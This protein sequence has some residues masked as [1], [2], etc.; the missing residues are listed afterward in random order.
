MGVDDAVDD[1]EPEALP[2]V[3]FVVKKGSKMRRRVSA[4][5]PA[6]RVGHAELDVAR[7]DAS[8]NFARRVSPDTTSVPSVSVP[9][10]ASRRGR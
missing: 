9:P 8:G 4:S 3:P 2:L 7:P 5:M 6:A 10:W 1:G